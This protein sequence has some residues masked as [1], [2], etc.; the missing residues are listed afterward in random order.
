[1]KCEACRTICGAEKGIRA[2][3]R[4]ILCKDSPR[5]KKYGKC[6]LCKKYCKRDEEKVPTTTVEPVK[7]LEASPEAKNRSSHILNLISSRRKAGIARL[8]HRNK[9][10][11]LHE[12]ERDIHE[13][14]ENVVGA[15]APAEEL[16]NPIMVS[17]VVA[18][19][20]DMNGVDLSQ[21][22]PRYYT[23]G[24]FKPGP[25]MNHVLHLL[26]VYKTDDIEKL[27][28]IAKLKTPQVS[29]QEA[30]VLIDYSKFFS[31][32]DAQNAPGSKVEG[33]SVELTSEI[34]KELQMA[35]EQKKI[36]K[37]D[38]SLTPEEVFKVIQHAISLVSYY[39]ATPG[40]YS[41]TYLFVSA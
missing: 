5:C 36:S 3:S 7:P 28:V 1:M 21:A 32:V 14:N 37:G 24:A 26:N 40:N 39:Q 35:G 9:P 38:S 29:G 10:K 25:R 30:P 6:D 13:S 34:D 12:V 20:K 2:A 15:A 4:C 11:V 19:A 31:N 41:T 23:V 22:V 33:P 18:A 17:P 16:C 27:I 8:I